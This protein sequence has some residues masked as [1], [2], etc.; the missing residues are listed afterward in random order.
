[1]T[2]FE[3]IQRAID[4]I[5]THLQE[6]MSIGAI[7]APTNYSAFHFQRVFRAISGFSV[8]AYIRQRRLTEAA[9]ML[10]NPQVTVLDAAVAYGY[11]SHEA[12]TRAFE[13]CFAMTPSEYRK[14][15][16]KPG[17]QRRLDLCAGAP[18]RDGVGGKTPNI[19]FLEIH[20]VVG[21]V[22]RTSLANS[23]FY[24]DIGGFY[25]D[26]G[27]SSG[28]L[29]IPERAKPGWCHGISCHFQDDG[30]FDFVIGEK[31]I[32]PAAALPEGFAA[33]HLPA[34][35][36]AEFDASGP[37]D[38]VPR[39]RDYI[40]GTWLPNSRYERTDGPDFE[41]NDVCSSCFPDDLRIKV[42]IPLREETVH[43]ASSP[44]QH[45]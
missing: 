12:F 4:F 33:I 15:R 16:D 34:G 7:A 35:W 6:P 8:Q 39:I 3:R 29:H 43:Q 45:P 25:Q 18:F 38:T 36:Y 28:Y 23:N 13:T 2:A 1:M 11:G 5:E 37:I 19:R 41:I 10:T 24:A 30:Q 9:Q 44:L 21:K 26:F 42:Y 32:Q 31:V 14:Q 40:Y 27:E 17:G 22:Y 20:S